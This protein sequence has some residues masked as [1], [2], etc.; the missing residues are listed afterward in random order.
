MKHLKRTAMRRGLSVIAA[1]LATTFVVSR[2]ASAQQPLY[3]GPGEDTAVVKGSVTGDQFADYSF[4][5]KRGTSMDVQLN[6]ADLSLCFN[7]IDRNSSVAIDVDPPPREVRSWSG[8][9]PASGEYRI[10]LYLM[11]AARDEN[12]T[13]RFTMTVKSK[14]GHRIKRRSRYARVLPATLASRKRKSKF[15]SFQ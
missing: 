11:G 15:I 5:A 7:I 6:S 9:I 10:R 1:A 3:W 14:S 4:A 8:T 13:G 2:P 12:K